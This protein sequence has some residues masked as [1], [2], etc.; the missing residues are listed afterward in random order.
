MCE[1]SEEARSFKLSELV[2]H[3][4]RRRPGFS[5]WN[6]FWFTLWRMAGPYPMAYREWSVAKRQTNYPLRLSILRHGVTEE[7]ADGAGTLR[8]RLKCYFWNAPAIW[9][10]RSDSARWYLMDSLQSAAM[11]LRFTFGIYRPRWKKWQCIIPSM[12]GENIEDLRPPG[13]GDVVDRSI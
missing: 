3:R 8:S 9:G 12:S 1:R 11:R 6:W 10:R 2:E 4:N 5:K 7:T 13:E